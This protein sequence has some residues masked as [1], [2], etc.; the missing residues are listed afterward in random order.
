MATLELSFNGQVIQ[1]IPLGKENM[2]IGRKPDNDI[3]IDNLAVSSH[4][5]KILTI[6]NDS[7]VEDMG[8][9]NGTYL[10]GTL[11][12]KQV[13]QHNDVI[14]VGKHEL[15]YINEAASSNDDFEK[16][17]ILNP[18]AEGMPEDAGNQAI[19]QSVGKIAAE[20]AS[21]DSGQAAG[22]NAK[23]RVLNGANSGVEL[24]LTKVLTTLGKP[25]VQ[26]AAITRRP[27]GY[28][29]IHIDGGDNNEKPKVNDQAIS[30]QAQPL[31]N[32]DVIEVAGVKMTFFLE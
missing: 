13:L 21:A 23:I 25:G 24:A 8:S 6:L 20:I 28:F 5:A 11:I 30:A 3:Q 27:S 9:T 26:V 15:K 10:N 14:K 16:T 1:Q 17:M 19:D 7:F 12:K 32:N 31:N 18:G 22:S 29:L 2:T 4:H